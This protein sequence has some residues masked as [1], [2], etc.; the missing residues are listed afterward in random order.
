MTGTYRLRLGLLLIFL[1]TAPGCTVLGV[2]FAAENESKA[3][4]VTLY[5]ASHILD[6]VPFEEICDLSADE[7]QPPAVPFTSDTIREIVERTKPAVLNVY[8]H[9][10][11]PVRVHLLFVPVPGVPAVNIPGEALGSAFVCSAEGYVL[12]NAHVVSRAETLKGKMESGKLH[13]L[14]ILAVDRK[15][16]L[17]L[18]RIK[19]GAKLESVTLA[20]AE[21]L[22]EGDWVI[23][24]G[25]PLGLNHSVSHGIISQ[26]ARTLNADQGGSGAKQPQFLQSDAP[27]NP[28]NSGGP[29]LDLTGRVVGINSAIARGAQGISFTIPTERIRA[30]LEQ[31]SGE[32]AIAAVKRQ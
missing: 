2:G 18:L 26:K 9:R 32:V 30:F 24:I 28:G 22:S 6:G 7:T 16:D 14:E 21:R 11:T 8:V 13:E 4:G 15:S 19:D 1:F 31:V 20:N 12:T 3:A 10:A 27:V 17:A 29:L 25:N 23:A 5:P